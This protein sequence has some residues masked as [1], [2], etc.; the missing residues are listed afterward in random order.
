MWILCLAEDS[1]ETSS[2]IFSEKQWKKHLWMPFAAVVI[3]VLRVKNKLFFKDTLQN[4]LLHSQRS[5]SP[6]RNFSQTTSIPNKLSCFRICFGIPVV[7]DIWSWFILTHKG[8]I[9][10]I[11]FVSM[12][13]YNNKMQNGVSI[14]LCSLIW[15]DFLKFSTVQNVL[16]TYALFIDFCRARLRVSE[17]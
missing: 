15:F 9:Y 12:N 2:L 14:C 11:L 3:G 17:T 6:T 7:C 13:C 10:E 16:K 1:L 4:T 5:I 8:P